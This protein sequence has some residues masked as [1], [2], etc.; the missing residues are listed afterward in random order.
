MSPSGPALE[1][2]APAKINLCLHVTGRRA[3][4]YHLLDSL[5]V[6]AD[7]DAADRVTVMLADNDR[8][9]VTGPETAALGTGNDTDNLAAKARD[10]LRAQIHA[11]AGPVAIGLEKN[12]PVASGI[13]GGSADAGATLRLLARLWKV[14][15]AIGAGRFDTMCSA[16]GADIAMCVHGGALRA[17]GIGERIE[18]V[19]ELPALPSVLVNP[20]IAVATP[21]VFAALETRNNAP[22]PSLPSGGFADPAA[23]ADW[24]TANTRNDLA[25]PARALVPAIDAVLGALE[26]S[27]TL[28]ARMSG[29][30]ATCFGLFATRQHALD[31][32]ETMAGAWPDWWIRPTV[33]NAGISSNNRKS[34][35]AAHVEA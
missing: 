28:M 13:G 16:L 8:L 22:I 34:I 27:G 35:G 2:R 31:A 26:A 9:A 7:A 14:E 6:F 20:R 18:P 5:V 4:G 21:S 15:A 30:G 19:D 10:W 23:L 12:L 33:L 24:L 25:P 32:A 3:D 29:S 17:R 1:A 11:G